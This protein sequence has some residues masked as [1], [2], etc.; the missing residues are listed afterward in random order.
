MICNKN[1][2]TWGNTVIIVP[3]EVFLFISSEFFPVVSDNHRS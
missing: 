3:I 2:Y 1:Y